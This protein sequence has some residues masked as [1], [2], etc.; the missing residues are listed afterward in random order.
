MYRYKISQ[1]SN[2]QQSTCPLFFYAFEVRIK[3]K[4]KINQKKKQIVKI[5]FVY[6]LLCL[7]FFFK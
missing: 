3:S 1:K 5:N 7:A 4:N 6:V 2:V